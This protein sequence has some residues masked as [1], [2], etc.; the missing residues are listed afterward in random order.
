MSGTLRSVAMIAATL[1][2]GLT[3]GLFFS[4]SVAVMLGLGKTD[5]RSFVATMQSI[6]REILNG[7]FMLAFMGTLIFTAIAGLFHLGKD[8]R[9]VLVWIAIAF[10]FSLL[11]WII[12][13]AFNVPLNNEIDAAG[14]PDKIKDLAAVREQFET[15][16]VRWNIFRTLTATAALGAMGWALVLYGRATGKGGA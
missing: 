15:A 5:D 4:F 8:Q 13:M 3:A 9:S 2:T 14:D 6:N 7:W 12:T 11:T 1:S 10:A 16:W